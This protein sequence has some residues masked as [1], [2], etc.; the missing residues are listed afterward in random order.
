[1]NDELVL[2][3]VCDDRYSACALRAGHSPFC[4]VFLFFTVLLFCF[5]FPFSFFGLFVFVFVLEFKKVSRFF[6]QNISFFNII[7]YLKFTF[8]FL[9]WSK[10]KYVTL[11]MR[12]L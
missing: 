4:F 5:V 1:M 9:S 8:Y 3:S 11:G 6:Y 10:N 12:L 7:F 2:T